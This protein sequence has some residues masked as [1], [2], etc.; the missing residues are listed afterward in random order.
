MPHQD[1]QHTIGDHSHLRADCANCFGLCCVALPF[2]ASA[3]FAVDKDAGRPC[4]NLREDFRCGVH[5]R[6]RE[7]GFS[8]CTVF[9]CFGAG[10]RVSQGTF[11][12]RDWRTHPGTA[13]RVFDVFGVMRQLHELLWYLTE[14]LTRPEAR[15][16]HEELRRVR[17]DVDRLSRGTAEDIVDLDVAA[18]RGEVGDLLS[19]TSALVRGGVP[20]RTEDHRGA[21]L[22]GAGLRDADLAGATLRGAW[23]IAADLRRADLRRADLLG[24]DLRDADLRGADLT[25]AVFLTQPQANAARGDAATRLPAALDRPSHWET[26]RAA[27]G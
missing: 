1:Q 13:R 3:D 24:A 25:G 15:S 19:R 5:S 7:E 21:D 8:G 18:M 9:D 22:V 17:D 23:L 14:A 26:G 4:A 11:G 2:T 10:Q 20:G 12:G 27:A 16:L 6:L